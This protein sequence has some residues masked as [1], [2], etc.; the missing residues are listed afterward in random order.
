MVIHDDYRISN[1][2]ALTDSGVDMNCIH[3]GLV[4]TLRKLLQLLLMVVGEI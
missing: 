4:P 3:E 1:A 2:I